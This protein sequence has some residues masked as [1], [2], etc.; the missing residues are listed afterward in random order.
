MSG[1][2][3][4]FSVESIKDTIYKKITMDGEELKGVDGVTIRME[5]NSLST[6]SIEFRT[7]AVSVNLE[8]EPMILEA[9]H[10]GR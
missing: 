7:D 5:V 3:H 6:V 8:D 9:H 4:N 1:I 2:F 10:G